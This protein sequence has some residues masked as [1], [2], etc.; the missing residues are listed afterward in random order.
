M[1]QTSKGGLRKHLT[2]VMALC[3]AL[4]SLATSAL[5][6]FDAKVYSSSMPVYKKASVSSKKLGSL[7]KGTKFVVVAS[8]SSWARIS[9]K[10]YTGYARISDLV[11]VNRLKVYTNRSTTVYKEASSSSKKLGTVATGTLCYL[12]GR[13]G[14]FF[15]VQNKSGKITGYVYKNNLSLEKPKQTPPTD[16]KPSDDNDDPVDDDY[17]VKMP[18][19]Y[20]STVSRY[21]PSLTEAQKLE[22]VI[23][24][25][26]SHLGKKYA[27]HPKAPT[28]FDCAG[29]VR[30]AYS[31]AKF[32][33]ESSA[34][35]QGYDDTYTKISK[36]SELKRGD[37]VCFNTNDT[38]SDLSDHTGIYL[39]G[40]YFIHASS[41]AGLVIVS[42]LN[43][44]YYKEA[45]SWGRRIAD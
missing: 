44:G 40:G 6:S 12:A 5:A 39:G 22:Y 1:N 36:I 9:Y 7:K 25:A 41:G 33:V 13:N 8:N 10:G 29:L 31:A 24:V 19:A 11:R 30:Y 32:D 37:M 34:Y 3:L 35:S 17:R 21:S 23:Y 26:Q 27:A 14:D 20:K 2:R 16:P 4:M 45:F 15:M 28:T 42:T 38:D 43:S 18:A